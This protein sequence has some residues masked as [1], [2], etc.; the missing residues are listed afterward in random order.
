[1]QKEHRI[2]FIADRHYRPKTFKEQI[3][4]TRQALRSMKDRGV[5][6]LFDSGDL[7]D[8]WQIS[9]S[10]DMSA[11]T[12]VSELNK[13]ILETGIPTFICEGN[14]DQ[15]PLGSPSALD[16]LAGNPLVKIFKEG[17][18]VFTLPGC[19]YTV[20]VAIPWLRPSKYSGDLTEAF[21]CELE[22]LVAPYRDA[23][24]ETKIKWRIITFGHAEIAGTAP[25]DRNKI[26]PSEEALTK[27]LG[28]HDSYFGHIHNR[29]QPHT[30]RYIGALA[31]LNF[32]E[33]GNSDGWVEID[34][35]QAGYEEHTLEFPRYI[36][37]KTEKDCGK[38]QH[39]DYVKCPPELAEFAKC[40]TDNVKIDYPKQV[41]ERK[42]KEVRDGF[43]YGLTVRDYFVQFLADSACDERDILLQVFES[44]N[45]SQASRTIYPCLIRNIKE[46]RYENWKGAKKHVTFTSNNWTAIVGPT[47]S[48]KTA[49]LES[50]YACF[51]GVFVS[52]DR[53]LSA[54]FKGGLGEIVV[55]FETEADTYQVTRLVGKSGMSILKNGK[56]FEGPAV[57]KASKKLE[58]IIGSKDIWTK[59]IIL[60]QE[61]KSN[62]IRATDGERFNILKDF[63]ELDE[64][65][66]FY[67]WLDAK[68]KADSQESNVA[69]YTKQKQFWAERFEQE[70]VK[71]NDLKKEVS[72]LKQA[73]FELPHAMDSS[74]A[75]KIISDKIQA[76]QVREQLSLLYS[77]I[78]NEFTQED[79]QELETARKLLKDHKQFL[80]LKVESETLD[81]AG[82]KANP[83][84][85]PFIDRATAARD[86]MQQEALLNVDKEV[87]LWRAVNTLHPKEQNWIASAINRRDIPKLEAK[88]LELNEVSDEEYFK[89]KENS[90]KAIARAVAIKQLESTEK[91]RDL[92]AEEL[93]RIKQEWDKAVKELVAFQTAQTQI[94][95]W[96]FI[97][98][99][100]SKENIPSLVMRSAIPEIQNYIEELIPEDFPLAVELSNI[101]ATDKE[102]LCVWVCKQTGEPFEARS[103]S[104]GQKDLLTLIFI[105]AMTRWLTGGKSSI[106]FL[107]EVSSGLDEETT[108]M[109]VDLIKSKALGQV[110]TTSHSRI[111]A[112]MADNVISFY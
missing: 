58:P 102:S 50:V 101:S 4:Y 21:L 84:P 69:Y 56:K 32:G 40:Y 106:L 63:L 44:L 94:D 67:K 100:F 41:R 24:D 78:P 98:D 6:W 8:N 112:S 103:A 19:P 17:M 33:D 36:N 76:K 29:N 73:I 96:K 59:T 20:F 93:T 104:G 23:C 99:A 71:F 9:T 80:E 37:I 26:Q 64:L 52:S 47:G 46:I 3:A 53:E 54:F 34:T 11:V 62:F 2:A 111:L 35:N 70:E 28:K 81:C 25:V 48:G 51:F 66:K 30:K 75:Q 92:K 14:H 72:K 45:Y 16:Y 97:R 22:A 107:D 83:L 12:M 108:I 60:T 42:H 13:L 88:L 79:K 27:I 65:T 18:S 90:D 105:L 5:S 38:V 74:A 86:A 95:L 10:L 85:C 39:T 49:L 15:G 82:C 77:R 91:Y 109:A 31:Q 110:I 55:T 43:N 68:I 89:A 7:F 87:D 57:T 61:R 1:M